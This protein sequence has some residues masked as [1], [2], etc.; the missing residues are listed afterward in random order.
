MLPFQASVF[1]LLLSMFFSIISFTYRHSNKVVISL[2]FMEINSAQMNFDMYLDWKLFSLSAIVSFITGNIMIY[3]QTYM[4][5]DKHKKR[6]ILILSL[7]A[8]SM[9]WT[10]LTSKNIM[11]M[12]IGWDFLGLT[13]LLLI[14]HY[15]SKYVYLFAMTTFILNRLGDISFIIAG[16]YWFNSGSWSIYSMTEKQ[17]FVMILMSIAAFTKS[18]QIP[19]SSWLPKAMA[20]PTPVSALVHSSTLV[21]AGVILIIQLE[22]FIM[23][24]NIKTLF[25]SLSILTML[26]SSLAAIMENDLK[27]IIAFSTMSQISMMMMILFM[28]N[29]NLAFFHL[30]TH[31]LFKSL[32]FMAAGTI[33]HH[34]ENEQDIRK[35]NNVS[36][37]LPLETIMINFSLLALMG[38]PF[39]SGF[40]SKDLI[41]EYYMVSNINPLM[42]ILID[43]SICMTS[44]YSTRLSMY[45]CWNNSFKNILFNWKTSL[46]EKTIMIMFSMPILS[47]GAMLMSLFISNF[48]F[49]L[50]LP[51]ILKTF[52]M[53]GMFL[54]IL[55]TLLTMNFNLKMKIIKSYSNSLGFLDLFMSSISI[56]TSKFSMMYFNLTENLWIKFLTINMKINIKNML[57][58][59]KLFN[60]NLMIKYIMFLLIMFLLIN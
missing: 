24:F 31:A 17:L 56:F 26:I 54:S 15:Q 50:P 4:N 2:S 35:I 23:S 21:T 37:M 52:S 42:I 46:P 41:I 22:P 34:S 28:G 47:S 9:I 8:L 53:W 45:L 33:I 3:S 1:F 60:F 19:F 27:K 11:P 5:S 20:A 18:A 16:A 7:F 55:T 58:N 48:N 51:K 49:E 30:L 44:M 25:M 29:A 32:M 6:F 12:L 59:K 39:Y 10:T 38:F 43:L 57:N 13:S 14:I 36:K 40:Y